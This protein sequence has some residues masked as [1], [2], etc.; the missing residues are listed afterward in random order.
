MGGKPTTTDRLQI[1][2]DAELAV[3]LE[4]LALVRNELGNAV[5]D[6]STDDRL[7][8]ALIELSDVEAAVHSVRRRREGVRPE[9]DAHATP[10]DGLAGLNLLLFELRSTFAARYGGWS[11]TMG[12]NRV[13]EGVKLYPYIS[14]GSDPAVEPRWPAQAYGWSG[15]SG[16][17]APD[18]GQGVG[19][20]V[21]DTHLFPH[22]DITGRYLADPRS[23][24][25]PNDRVFPSWAGH[26]TFISGLIVKCAPLVALDV[27]SVLDLDDATASAWDVACG[28]MRFAASGVD[29]LNLSFGCFTDDGQP[30]LILS[31][32]IDRLVNDVVI[33]AAAGNY[34]GVKPGES[35]L[36]PKTPIWPA[37]FDGVLAVGASD[38]SGPA[39]FSPDVPW[40]DLLA[41][42]VNL[43]ST[44]LRGNVSLRGSDGGT[45]T[46][47]HFDGYAEWSGTS[48]A[49]AIVSGA[50]AAHTRPGRRSAAAALAHLRQTPD[51]ASRYGIRAVT[52]DS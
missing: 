21:L 4:H 9:A 23:M 41:P 6:T 43:T 40:V 39:S 33:V 31:R 50:I 46:T 27:R 49:A 22:R 52:A 3:A 36:G 5:R 24:L 51:V 8:L 1:Y 30:P 2:Y 37:A 14:G 20:G 15:P 45:P 19:V 35:P 11:P 48:F 47:Q 28:L 16:N 38:G 13:M 42:G 25:R 29:V 12:K 10:P 34:G 26:S 7:G 44:Y 32:A 18:A 17:T